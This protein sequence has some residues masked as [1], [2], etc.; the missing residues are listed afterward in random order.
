MFIVVTLSIFAVVFLTC[1]SWAWRCWCAFSYSGYPSVMIASNSCYSL[2]HG[3]IR[4]FEWLSK[5]LRLAVCASGWISRK[6]PFLVSSRH[7]IHIQKP[8]EWFNGPE[9]WVT[10][11]HLNAS[12]CVCDL[13]TIFSPNEN[14]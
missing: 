13:N 2:V 12:V 14:I 1:L 11:L 9:Q 8:L 10:L 5:S 3:R 6:E 7:H 4:C